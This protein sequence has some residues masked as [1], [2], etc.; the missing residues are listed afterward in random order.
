MSENSDKYKMMYWSLRH[1]IKDDYQFY[2]DK[3]IEYERKINVYESTIYHGKVIEVTHNTHGIIK[4]DKYHDLFFHKSNVI[5]FTLDNSCEYLDVKFTV[6]ILYGKFQA[7]NVQLNETTYDKNQKF[8]L[9]HFLKDTNKNINKNITF[10]EEHDKED[11]KEDDKEE[12]EN[13]ENKK[14]YDTNIDE[15][16]T[17]WYMNGGKDIKNE[18]WNNYINNGFVKSWNHNNRN[19]INERLKI[20][21]IIAWY[22]Q[23]KG[24]SAILRV[25]DNVTTFSDEDILKIFTSNTNSIED[26]DKVRG[27]RRDEKKYLMHMWK[28]PVEFLA[29]TNDIHKCITRYDLNYNENDWTAGLRG[30]NCMRPNNDKWKDQVIDIYKKLKVI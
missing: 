17:I 14:D 20:G 12:D 18:F 6:T 2:K 26:F 11:D 19:R 8:T 13:I 30:S 21:D 5:G 23:G 25:C 24:Y 15:A 7:I 10:K 9:K 27:Y 4:N 16:E 29:H 3:I 22:F 1:E 28:I